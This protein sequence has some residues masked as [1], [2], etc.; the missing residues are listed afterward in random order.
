EADVVAQRLGERGRAGELGRDDAR[1]R[2]RCLVADQ[3]VVENTGA[4]HDAVDAAVAAVD[5]GGGGGEGGAGAR[6]G[7]GGDGGAGGADGG[8][9]GADL[10]ISEDACA[11]RLDRG[12]LASGAALEQEAAQGRRVGGG[13]QR[14]ILVGGRQLRPADELERAAV[15]AGE[16]DRE[17]RGD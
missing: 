2:L 3:L 9:G 15:A 11:Q 5:V 6:G 1:E 16:L 4:V 8:E 12:G 13:R 7:G 10:A 14:G 17:R